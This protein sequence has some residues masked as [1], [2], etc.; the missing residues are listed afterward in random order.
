MKVEPS[1]GEPNRKNE[2]TI[3]GESILFMNYN[4]NKKFI[5]LNLKD[6]RGREIFLDLAKRCDVVLENFRPGVMDRLG[7]GYDDL[8]RINPRIVYA[9]SSGYGTNGPY[10]D[11]AAY[12]T[13]IQAMTGIMELTGPEDSA[14]MRSAPAFVDMAGGTCCALAIIAALYHREKTG[15]GQRVDIAMYDVAINNMIGLYSFMQGNMLAKTGNWVPVLAPYNVYKAI[16]GYVVI[17]IGENS[18]WKAFLEAI[19]RND[20]TSDTRFDSIN[21]RLAHHIEIDNLISNWVNDKKSVDVVELVRR[22][23]GAAGPVR[24]IRALVDDPQVK[25]REMMVDVQHPTIGTF[26]TLGSAFKM[27]ETPGKVRSPGLPL[28]H[29]NEEIYGQMLGFDK[30]RM[31]S[32]RAD[33]VI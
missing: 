25:A 3:D 29:D 18:R 4:C 1:G 27:S 23:G 26:R 22:A 19:G 9:S 31:E 7:V 20:L 12:D 10:R 24:S 14:P 33:G 8:R 11:E 6:P 5:T 15:Q 16:D 17:I 13:L 32:L 2:P 21:S 28:G 30:V